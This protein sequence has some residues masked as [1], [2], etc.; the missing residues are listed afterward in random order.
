MVSAGKQ[1]I[2]T[3]RSCVTKR[4]DH[5]GKSCRAVT[6][7]LTVSVSPADSDLERERSK[8][9]VEMERCLSS[10]THT[11]VVVNVA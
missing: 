10:C 11:P 3:S 7:Q 9:R 1:E 8:E 6:S 2:L 4:R 5:V